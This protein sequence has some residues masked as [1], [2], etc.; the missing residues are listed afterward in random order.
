[1]F[2]FLWKAQYYLECIIQLMYCMK[3][4]LLLSYLGCKLYDHLLQIRFVKQNVEESFIS[5]FICCLKRSTL[6]TNTRLY[7]LK[8]HTLATIG[9][10]CGA[11]ICIWQSVNESA[12]SVQHGRSLW[13]QGYLHC[14]CVCRV[15]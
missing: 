12:R 13:V 9:A 4:N 5:G 6:C 10:Q 8:D 2:D 15:D 11:L 7:C 1:M 3:L 14:N